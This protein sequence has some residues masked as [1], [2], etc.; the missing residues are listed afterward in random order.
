MT[1]NV[2]TITYYNIKAAEYK[3]LVTVILYVIIIIIKLVQLT[4]VSEGRPLALVNHSI[5][6]GRWYTRPSNTYKTTDTLNKKK[7]SSYYYGYCYTAHN[8]I[9]IYV[10]LY[11]A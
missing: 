2:L 9:V 6:S 5:T 10:T 4:R 11:L 3:K 8:T 1:L 7:L